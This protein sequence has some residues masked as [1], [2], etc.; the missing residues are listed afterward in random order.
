MQDV[1]RKVGEVL[2]N[3]VV[4]QQDVQVHLLW[5]GVCIVG[6]VPPPIP[7]SSSLPVFEHKSE[8]SEDGEVGIHAEVPSE[9]LN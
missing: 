8:Q 4:R 3:Y 5:M 6:R 2:H 9:D 1:H 7:F